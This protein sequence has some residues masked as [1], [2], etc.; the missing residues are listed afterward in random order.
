MGI[1]LLKDKLRGVNELKA[2]F[3]LW[4]AGN[5]T[6]LDAL[7]QAI[8][9]L[10]AEYLDEIERRNARRA[11]KAAAAAQA[12]G[13]VKGFGKGKKGKQKGQPP[14]VTCTHC[15]KPN[16]EA[17]Q[18]WLNPS[19]SSYRPE[20][21]S[22]AA[23]KAALN[24]PPGLAGSSAS[25]SGSNSRAATT[26]GANE[27][28]TKAFAEFLSKKFAG[29]ALDVPVEVTQTMAQFASGA[30][31]LDSGASQCVV[32]SSNIEDQHWD[33][34][35]ASHARVEGVTG[36][37]SST[38]R[39][40][41]EVPHL[42][43]CN[44]IVMD[45]SVNMACM[46]EACEDLGYNFFWPAWSKKTHFWK[47]GEVEEVPLVVHSR[48]PFLLSCIGS[49]MAT[50]MDSVYDRLLAAAAP[51]LVAQ[52]APNFL[53]E[54]IL[55][56]FESIIFRSHFGSSH[57]GSSVAQVLLSLR[58]HHA[59][60]DRVSVRFDGWISFTRRPREETSS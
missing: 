52:L 32:N 47:E 50:F 53:Q 41:V 12:A 59:C 20:L 1:S 7:L 30:W 5:S 28:L 11:V 56:F 8:E 49:D 4:S 43:R 17:K 51:D 44:A 3:A 39:V 45:G 27:A 31:A 2:T 14:K 42:G 35:Q 26:F 6:D 21:A 33:T 16:H 10:Q 57:F 13:G 40:D 19:S 22:K 15:G 18:C 25:S 36:Q 34:L 58:S 9:N 29:V 48:V 60:R 54:I 37:A 24:P 46:G 38:A 23:A 55:E